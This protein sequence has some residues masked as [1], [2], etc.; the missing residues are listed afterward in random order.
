MYKVIVCINRCKASSYNWMK[1]NWTLYIQIQKHTKV[2]SPTAQ[3]WKI[4][5]NYIFKDTSNISFWLWFCKNTA[6][7]ESSTDNSTDASPNLNRRPKQFD[8]SGDGNTDLDESEGIFSGGRIHNRL[9]FDYQWFKCTFLFPVIRCHQPSNPCPN[10]EILCHIFD[11][12][13]SP[14]LAQLSIGHF[15]VICI[16]SNYTRKFLFIF[17]TVLFCCS[18]FKYKVIFFI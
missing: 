7:K 2:L 12:Y 17:C 4:V 8:G 5:W 10:H 9:L 13:W 3:Y 15:C 1:L 16:I 18:Y 11:N 6:L 14:V